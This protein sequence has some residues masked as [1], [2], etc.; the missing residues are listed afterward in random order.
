[1]NTAAFLVALMELAKEII[2]A[3]A[4]KGEDPVDAVEALRLSLRLGVA[5]SV[6]AEI[7]AK[8]NKAG[9]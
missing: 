2:E 9:R 8:F 4:K 1:M 3:S 5:E 6:Q 7:D